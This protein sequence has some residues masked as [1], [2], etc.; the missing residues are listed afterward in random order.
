MCSGME[1]QC[2]VFSFEWF[3]LLKYDDLK[4]LE[5]GFSSFRAQ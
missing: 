1:A 3:N 5:V 4:K 2:P